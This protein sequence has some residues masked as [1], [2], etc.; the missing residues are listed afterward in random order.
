MLDS[1]SFVIHPLDDHEAR[2]L[3]EIAR[4]DRS[5]EALAAGACRLGFLRSSLRGRLDPDASVGLSVAHG[6]ALLALASCP[7]ASPAQRS[8]KT[9]LIRSWRE[10][11]GDRGHLDVMLAAA[12]RA[13]RPGPSGRPVPARG[14]GRGAR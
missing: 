2:A 11:G 7:S 12:L 13:D 1:R 9:R 4:A 6:D 10:E 8:V 5:F 14:Q 3:R